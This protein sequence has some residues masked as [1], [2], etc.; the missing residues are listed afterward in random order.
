[1]VTYRDF[2]WRLCKPAD[3]LLSEM[4][5]GK[6]HIWH[7]A[8]ALLDEAVELVH[9]MQQ[10]ATGDATLLEAKENVTEELGDISFY[11]TGLEKAPEFEEPL[12]ATARENVLL[13]FDKLDMMAIEEMSSLRWDQ[14]GTDDLCDLSDFVLIAAGEVFD[15]IK[16]YVIYNKPFHRTGIELKLH[17]LRHMIGYVRTTW[18]L[19]VAEIE[20]HNRAKLQK[21]YDSLTYSDSAAHD[22]ADKK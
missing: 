20:A 13:S 7:M 9:G 22:R 14:C 8:S 1:V 16:Q 4:T 15:T 3:V 10:L 19:T 6:V 11:M 21:R 2:V 18:E 17:I 12:T 5:E